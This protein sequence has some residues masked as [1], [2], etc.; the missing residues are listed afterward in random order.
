MWPNCNFGRKERE[1][2]R[3]KSR[4][5]YRNSQDDLDA[6]KGESRRGRRKAGRVAEAIGLEAVARRKTIRESDENGRK[7]NMSAKPERQATAR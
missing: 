4:P 6:E 7:S 3:E 2:E 5:E 1:P